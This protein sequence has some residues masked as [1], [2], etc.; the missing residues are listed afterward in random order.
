MVPPAASSSTSPNQPAV[1]HPQW[2]IFRLRL[3]QLIQDRKRWTINKQEIDL[4]LAKKAL[5]CMVKRYC[6]REKYLEVE[7][8]THGI[9][10]Y[11]HGDAHRLPQLEDVRNMKDERARAS[12]VAMV[13]EFIDLEEDKEAVRFISEQD[14][15]PEV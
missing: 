3:D 11:I 9:E 12:V 7:C 10:R 4:P 15:E 8:K 2:V 13:A 14:S 1:D 5:T 6:R